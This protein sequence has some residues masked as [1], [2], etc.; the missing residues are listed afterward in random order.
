MCEKCG[1]SEETNHAHDAFHEEHG[2]FMVVEQDILAKNNQLASQNQAMFEKEN[3]LAFNMMSS[4]GSGKT[5]LLA[6]TITDLNDEMTISVIVGD[7][8]TDADAKQIQNSGAQAI[9]INTGR[10]CHLDAHMVGHAAEQLTLNE[11]AVVFI[12]NVGNLVCPAL[13]NLGE[14]YKIV[15]LSVTEGENKPLKYPDM[16]HSADLMLVT[17]MDLL[18]YVPFDLDQCIEYARRINPEIDIIT[19]SVLSG[20]GLGDWYQWIRECR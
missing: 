7:Q 4:P 19:L 20:V 6:K 14:H 5:T 15:V 2:H 3:V 18:P 9:Q 8:Q 11:N 10:G 1:C 17:K 12:E 13:F 16:F